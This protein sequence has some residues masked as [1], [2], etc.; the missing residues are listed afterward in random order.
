MWQNW[1]GFLCV[2]CVIFMCVSMCNNIARCH[3]S[4]TET[5]QFNIKSSPYQLLQIGFILN[6]HAL[7]CTPMQYIC[8]LDKTPH[9]LHLYVPLC[10]CTVCE[11]MMWWWEDIKITPVQNV[12]ALLTPRAIT[13]FFSVHLFLFYNTFTFYS[14]TMSSRQHRLLSGQ[15]THL[16]L[17]FNCLISP[18]KNCSHHTSDLYLPRVCFPLSF[19]RLSWQAEIA[20]LFPQSLSNPPAATNSSPI[21][22]SLS[23]RK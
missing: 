9:V 11:F 17:Q 22:G 13:V 2:S 3:C 16:S 5:P 1:H 18:P 8:A 14:A 6:S 4:K 7:T 23:E 10:L 20:L 19:L 15:A 12:K 21:T